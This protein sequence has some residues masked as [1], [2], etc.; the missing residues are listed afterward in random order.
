MGRQYRAVLCVIALILGSESA[1]AQAGSP[2][3][4]ALRGISGPRGYKQRHNP[5][6]CEGIYRA[7]TSGG[8]EVLS[9]AKRLSGPGAGTSG[10]IEI[11]VP[12]QPDKT[13]RINIRVR[14]LR[15]D[16]YYR[17]DVVATAG[18]TVGWPS[19]EVLDQ[20][21]ITLNDLGFLGWRQA[22]SEREIV[23]LG[24][25]GSVSPPPG[26]S[27]AVLVVRSPLPLEWVQWRMYRPGEKQS[28]YRKMPGS[29]FP[30]GSPIDIQIP[31]DRTGLH[32]VE[33]YAMP[34][35]QD[36]PEE[37]SLPLLL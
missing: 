3:D 35:N 25:K 14:T 8:I 34:R 15:E 17:M 4:P 19:S 24:V 36:M 32:I 28:T 27:A 16:L 22:G 21:G 26:G 31:M 10:R 13:S 18:A 5:D 30:A 37:L 1:R 6:R 2:C 7:P 33:V 12:A 9:F 29:G 23:P 20:V 11:E